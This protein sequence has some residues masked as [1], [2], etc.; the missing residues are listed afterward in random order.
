MMATYLDEEKL[1][2]YLK[3]GGNIN[4]KLDENDTLLHLSALSICDTEDI[5][6]FRTMLASGADVNAVNNY[7]ESPLY[8][9]VKYNDSSFVKLFLEFGAD[10]TVLDAEGKNILSHAAKFNES[11]ELFDFLILDRGLDVNHLSADGATAMHMACG[12]EFQSP[13]IIK[14]LLKNGADSN[15]L[16]NRGHSSLMVCLELLIR[17]DEYLE[18]N[19]R[20]RLLIDFTEFN[21]NFL[22]GI[23]P[24]TFIYPSN[25]EY[26]WKCIIEHIAKLKYL[27]VTVHK[28]M[29]D[30]I[31][32]KNEYEVHHQ[33]CCTELKLA[34]DTK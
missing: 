29:I 24:L 33:S 17:N 30:T 25:K 6:F 21:K 2:K 20:L 4:I 13:K 34:K 9:V 27:M 7:G 1:E 31:A 19:K 16:N 14:N 28:K 26:L 5:S 18:V 23:N 32:E 15:I 12:S 10:I 8:N 22:D 3:E 11:E